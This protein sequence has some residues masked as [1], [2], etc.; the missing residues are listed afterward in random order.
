MT[1]ANTTIFNLRTE[2]STLQNKNYVIQEKLKSN[3]E[4]Q[5]VLN[6]I[7]KTTESIDSTKAAIDKKN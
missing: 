1:R 4:Y 7:T 2:I 5:A 6:I 3:S